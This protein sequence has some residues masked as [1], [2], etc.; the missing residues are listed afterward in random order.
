MKEISCRL[1]VIGAGPGGY[2]CAIRAGQLGVDTV[3]VEM[4]KP[5]GTCLNVGCI[6][7]KALIHAADE[8]ALA[9]RDGGRQRPY[10]HKRVRSQDRSRPDRRVEGRHRRPAEQRRGR[11]PEEGRGQDRDWPRRVPRREDGR[12][13][14]G[15]RPAAH[16]RGKCGDRH[17]LGFGRTAVAA[18]RRQCD[19]IHRGAGAGEGAGKA[20]R[21]RR[22]LYRTGTRHRL[23]Q[24]GRQGD[25]GRSHGT[26]PAAI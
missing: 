14:D 9:R 7:S 3:I 24:D 23:R 18:V 11:A 15:D 20:C 5:G 25:G 22:R 17:R 2:V 1:L 10:R 21:G 16:P 6:P 19:L 13:G 26:H 12:G 8:F 4:A